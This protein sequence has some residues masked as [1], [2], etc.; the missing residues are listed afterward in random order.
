MTD[1]N[2]KM[3]RGIRLNKKYIAIDGD[4]ISLAIAQTDGLTIN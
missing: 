3:E 1:L 2:I 4:A